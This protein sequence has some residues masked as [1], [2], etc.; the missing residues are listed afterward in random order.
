M[1]IAGEV[2]VVS[3]IKGLHRIYHWGCINFPTFGT[4]NVINMNT[5]LPFFKAMILGVEDEALWM[6]IGRYLPVY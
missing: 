2:S 4:V 6:F 1:L 5:S 3:R